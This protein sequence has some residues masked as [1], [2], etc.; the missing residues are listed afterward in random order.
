MFWT[1]QRNMSKPYTFIYIYIVELL[2]LPSRLIQQLRLSLSSGVNRVRA[3][4]FPQLRRETGKVSKILCI[5][6]NTEQWTKS[7]H[8]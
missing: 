5:F 1:E 4:P 7:Q 2:D 3:F 8:R 6:W